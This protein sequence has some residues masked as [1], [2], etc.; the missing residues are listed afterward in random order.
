MKKK[1]I[2]SY[3]HL[4][5]WPKVTY[6]KRVRA[7]VLSNCLAKTTSKLVHSFSWN[8][9]HKKSWTHTQTNCS[10]N[11]TPPW[12]HVGVKKRDNIKMQNLLYF[13]VSELNKKGNLRYLSIITPPPNCGGV[14][15]TLQFCECMFVRNRLSNSQA[16]FAKRSTS[17][18]NTISRLL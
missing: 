17:N 18:M 1:W 11:I 9:V 14:I 4:D 13:L 5:L 3:C 2:L 8:F 15:F 12:F 6:F 10:E 7:S 16:I